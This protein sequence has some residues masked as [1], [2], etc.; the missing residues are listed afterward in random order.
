MW[1]ITPLIH[2]Y[3]GVETAKGYSSESG[4]SVVSH[5]I[6][7]PEQGQQQVERTQVG[8]G[9]FTNEVGPALRESLADL[10]D[11]LETLQSETGGDHGWETEAVRADHYR[12]D[13]D[14]VDEFLQPPA[15]LGRF[16]GGSRHRASTTSSR[17]IPVWR[18]RASWWSDPTGT[19]R[20]TV[21]PRPA[22]RSWRFSWPGIREA[23]P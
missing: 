2:A 18:R 1:S 19:V 3:N 10:A 11:R 22:R 9:E 4:I 16:L 6:T 8:L 5:D 13:G 21:P 20:L 12:L 14:Y 17:T 7:E 23:G 15:V